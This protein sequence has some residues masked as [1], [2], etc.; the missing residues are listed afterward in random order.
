RLALEGIAGAVGTGAT[1]RLRDY[2]AGATTRGDTLTATIGPAPIGLVDDFERALL[3]VGEETGTLDRAFQL[4]AEWYQAHYRFLAGM[5]RRSTYPLI[6]TLA[7][8]VLLPLPL[9]VNGRTTTYFAIATTGVALWLLL[10]G[11][12]VEGAARRRH[13]G[14][15]RASARLAR[16]LT[17][18]LE[19]GL[20]IDRSIDLAVAAAADDAVTAH[21]RRVNPVTRRTQPVSETFRGCPVI[22]T[23]MVAAMR[24]A[25]ESGNWRST[26]GRM[27]ELYEDGF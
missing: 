26:V 2:L 14:G 12:L 5:W 1:E 17:T 4:L 19:A 18:A 3:A 21:V 20:P 10:G 6:V 25:E 8:A 22:P 15:R 27:G 16:A 11:S 13:G 24:V 23:E 9:V 7:A